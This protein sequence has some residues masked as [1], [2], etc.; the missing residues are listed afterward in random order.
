MIGNFFQKQRLRKT[1]I[2]TQNYENIQLRN[3]PYSIWP[4][5][6]LYLE[7]KEEE[8]IKFSNN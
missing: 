5:A 3:P 7:P 8:Q 4:I 2:K 6:C 1:E